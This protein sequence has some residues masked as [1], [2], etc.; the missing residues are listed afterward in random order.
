MRPI[1]SV[2]WAISAATPGWQIMRL[3]VGTLIVFGCVFGSYAQM[4]GHLQVLWQPFEFV[5]ILG[6]AIGAF[7]IGNV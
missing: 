3:L 6:A 7:I 4:G 1:G 5:I 2:A